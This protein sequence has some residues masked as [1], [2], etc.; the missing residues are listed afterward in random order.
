MVHARILAAVAALLAAVPAAADARVEAGTTVD[1][2]EMPTLAGGKERLIGR[3][4]ANVILFWRPGNERSLDTLKQMAAC[5]KLFAGKSVHMVTVVSGSYAA[6]DIKA[7]VAQADIHLPVL[8]DVND[9]AYGRL[10]IRQHPVVLVADV[11]GVVTLWQ[12]YVRIRYC[13]IVHAHVRYLLGELDEAQ[14]DRELHPPR[15]SFPSDDKTN[16]AKRYLTMGQRE[17]ARGHC[18]QARV[19]FEKA[20][21]LAPGLAEAE[22]AMKACA[23]QAAAK[24]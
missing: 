11:R 23:E 7:A 5:E 8:L 9:A 3:A 2:L 17:A 19:S 21:E 18:D 15:A 20:L 24:R 4:A 22:A 14:L 12:P 10:Q 6:E 13:E 16:V 1:N